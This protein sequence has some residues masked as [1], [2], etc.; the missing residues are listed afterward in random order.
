MNL[1][2]LADLAEL[3][4]LYKFVKFWW[5][6]PLGLADLVDLTLSSAW[7]ELADLAHLRVNSGKG[8]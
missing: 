7:A 8:S 2:D 6:G 5:G 3:A 1:A 4:Y